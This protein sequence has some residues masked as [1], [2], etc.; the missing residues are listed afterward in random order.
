MLKTQKLRILFVIP[1]L[2]GGGAEILLG[3][4]I[5]TLHK[6][7][8]NILLVTTNTDHATYSNFPNKEFID[9]QI[10]KIICQTKVTFSIWKGLKINNNHFQLIV[11]DFKPDIIHS[12]LFEAEIVVKSF[13]VIDFRYVI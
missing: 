7:G 6:R 1:T 8:H 12:H 4:I 9:T 10:K 11:E 5:E 2:G 13:M 3:N